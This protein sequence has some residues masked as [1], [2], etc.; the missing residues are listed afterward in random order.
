MFRW[1][2][3]ALNREP[4]PP[5]SPAA[6]VEAEEE[7]EKAQESLRESEGEAREARQ[8]AGR[9]ERI[10]RENHFAERALAAL[11]GIVHE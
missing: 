10:N 1:L 8:V 3:K 2:R 5:P 11:K 7:L 9:L 4:P 6:Q